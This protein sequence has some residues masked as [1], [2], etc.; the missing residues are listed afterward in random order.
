MKIIKSFAVAALATAASGEQVRAVGE[1]HVEYYVHQY[2]LVDVDYFHALFSS[3]Y[4]A[5]LASEMFK[6]NANAGSFNVGWRISGRLWWE[7]NFGMNILDFFWVIV[8]SR[9]TLLDSHPIKVQMTV[10]D[11]V[12][13]WSDAIGQGTQ[14]CM[15]LEFDTSVLSVTTT[16]NINFKRMNISFF[17]VFNKDADYKV[18]DIDS[19]EVQGSDEKKK[20]EEEKPE[21]EEPEKEEPKKEEPK[22]EEPEEEEEGEEE[23]AA[24]EGEEGDSEVPSQEDF[25]VKTKDIGI[26]WKY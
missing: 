17:D 1:P 24:E 11:Y 10:P 12:D 13:Q 22:E 20:A 9:V 3:T 19:A 6:S 25:A 15:G 21:E 2:D 16:L 23:A 14:T 18:Q 8:A 26:N 5:E 4:L 7:I